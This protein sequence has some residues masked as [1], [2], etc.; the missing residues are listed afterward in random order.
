MEGSEVVPPNI[1]VLMT[2]CVFPFIF[3]GSSNATVNEVKFLITGVLTLDRSKWD[4][5]VAAVVLLN[6]T[7][8]SRLF[9]NPEK[10]AIF[11]KIQ[12]YMLSV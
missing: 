10:T 4:K 6:Y 1:N 2:D 8:R 11:W 9:D 7:C 3:C 12:T 5:S